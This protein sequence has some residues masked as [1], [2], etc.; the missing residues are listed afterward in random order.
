MY[1]RNLGIAGALAI[2]STGAFANDVSNNIIV[3]GGST[4]FGALHTDNADF[5]DVFNFIN[6]AGPVTANASLITIGS[7]FNNID[8]VSANLN[9]SPLTL[10]PNG[11]LETGMIGDTFLTGPLVLTVTGKSAAAGGTF[12]SYSG[13]MNV[14]EPQTWALLLAGV[15]GIALIA[16]RRLSV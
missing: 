2:A 10:S 12:A 9:G 11:F 1:L 6:I 13:T 15:V 5:T 7:G 3:A 4:F 8:F 16:R 14:P